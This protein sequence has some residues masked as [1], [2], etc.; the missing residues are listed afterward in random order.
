MASAT[1]M[2]RTLT[3]L[4][5]VL[6]VMDNHLL[7]ISAAV[8]QQGSCASVLVFSDLGKVVIDH[9]YLFQ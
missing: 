1:V 9:S 5:D 7:P 3:W 8:H 2:V 6:K 4:L